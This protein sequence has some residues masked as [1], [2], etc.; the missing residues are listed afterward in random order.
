MKFFYIAG[1]EPSNAVKLRNFK[2][3]EFVKKKIK[4]FF[5]FYKFFKKL[6][7]IC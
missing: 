1:T 4:L 6:C 3:Q 2:T 5:K 7:K